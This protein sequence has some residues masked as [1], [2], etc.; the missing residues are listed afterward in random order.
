MNNID[1][2]YTSWSNL[3]KTAGM[4]VGQVGFYRER[5]VRK[6][7]VEKR[8]NEIIN[9]LNKTK[10]DRKPDLRAEREERDRKVLASPFPS[11]DLM[12]G[13]DLNWLLT[14]WLY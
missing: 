5:E 10:Q 6:I 2:V 11:H 9:R 14:R 7:R 8:I 3:K 13:L 12:V 4:E 1:V